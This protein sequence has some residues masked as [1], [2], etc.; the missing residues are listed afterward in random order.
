[1][2]MA[3]VS[4]II[5]CYNAEMWVTEAVQSCLKQTYSD[6]E[7]IVVDDGSTDRSVQ[8]LKK[9]G[10]QIVLKSGP[11][12]GGNVARNEGFRLSTG[13]YV[14]FLDADDYL[15]PDKIA[16]QLRVLQEQNADVVYGDWRYQ[17]HWPNGFSY[18]DKIEESGA[19]NDIVSSLLS[20]WWVAQ[21]AILYRRAIVESV[22]GWDESFRA[23]QDRDFF[24][25]VAMANAKIVYRPGC[26]FIYRKYGEVTVSTSNIDRWFNSNC[27]SIEKAEATLRKAG[28]LSNMYKMALAVGYARALRFCLPIKTER[29]LEILQKIVDLVPEFKVQH[30]VGFVQVSPRNYWLL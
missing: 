27:L 8:V 20:G 23:A 16:T 7:I 9:F 19:Q 6:I 22:G 26:N 11:N 24:T 4:I 15:L 12:R 18:L 28:R 10:D 25:S 5:P 13:E 29:Q 17:F 1:M 3:T 30:R 2:H 21:G 14:V